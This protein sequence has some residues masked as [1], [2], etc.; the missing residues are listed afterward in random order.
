MFLHSNLSLASFSTKQVNSI[1]S[2]HAFTNLPLLAATIAVNIWTA[3]TIWHKEGTRINRL[4]ICDCA[5]NVLMMG[6]GTFAQSKWFVLD[7]AAL[8]SVAVFL[9]NVL[10]TWNRMVTLVIAMFRY[11]MVCHAVMCQNLGE[12]LVWLVLVSGLVLLSLGEGLVT[13][14][15]SLLPHSNSHAFLRCIGRQEL[16]RYKPSPFKYSA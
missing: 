16:F 8:C 3:I 6:L 2:V 10:F 14:V 13:V 4:I 1:S 9:L 11:V 5:A 15:Y 12:R 7:S